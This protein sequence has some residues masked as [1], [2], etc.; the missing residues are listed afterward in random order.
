MSQN[1]Q[2]LNI[3][4]IPLSITPSNSQVFFRQSL[5]STNLILH[6]MIQYSHSNFLPFHIEIDRVFLQEVVYMFY[7]FLYL[8]LFF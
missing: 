1:R 7:A 2:K 8:N 4:L 6:K 3:D 5:P